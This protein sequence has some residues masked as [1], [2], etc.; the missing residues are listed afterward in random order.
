LVQNC[1][2]EPWQFRIADARTVHSTIFLSKFLFDD[3]LSC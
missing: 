1:N 3:R 2:M